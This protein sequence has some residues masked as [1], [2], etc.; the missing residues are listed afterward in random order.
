M[1]GGGLAGLA[2]AV[3]LAEAGYRVVV[4]ERRPVLGG[5]ASS[6]PTGEGEES[7]DNCQH[8]LMRCCTALWHFYG[9]LEVQEKIHFSDRLIATG[10]LSLL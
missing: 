10:Q 6:S 1:I 9:L 4:H 5:R 3:M 2:A 8:V 7:V